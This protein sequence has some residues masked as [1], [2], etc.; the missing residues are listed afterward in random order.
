VESS[1]NHEHDARI[2]AQQRLRNLAAG[3]AIVTSV[4]SGI[5]LQGI[6]K[7]GSAR[8]LGVVLVVVAVLVSIKSANVAS[9][10]SRDDLPAVKERPAWLRHSLG[11][12]DRSGPIVY[13]SVIATIVMAVV[14]VR[15]NSRPVVN[16]RSAYDGVDPFRAGCA[17]DSKGDRTV[18]ASTRIEVKGSLIGTLDLAYSKY[19]GSHWPK[20]FLTPSGFQLLRRSLVTVVT[21]RPVDDTVASYSV[22][23]GLKP[24]LWGNMLGGGACAG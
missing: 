23:V 11:D 24:Y 18:I 3:I 8:A 13:A 6:V 2:V 4:A 15:L 5:G 10:L 21:H 12:R 7:G 9:N 22:V 14:A 20:V 1:E 19:C 16:Y 17:S